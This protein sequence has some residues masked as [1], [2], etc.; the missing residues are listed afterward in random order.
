MDARLGTV[1]RF[2]GQQRHAIRFL[3]AIPAALADALV[4]QDPAG[5]LRQLPAT[6][7]AAFLR[8]AQLVVDHDRDTLHALEFRKYRFEI[9]ARAQLGGGRQLGRAGVF[10]RV[11]TEHYD[12]ADALGLEFARQGG[13]G[14]RS[15]GLLAA[16][17]GNGIVVE[18]LEC[19]VDARGHGR[20]H[21]QATGVKVRAVTEILEDVL[22]A[23]E[24]LG[25]DPRGAFGTHL[26]QV[27]DAAAHI[28]HQ[29]AHAV[30]ADAAS[31]DLALEQQRGAI[32][33]AAGAVARRPRAPRRRVLAR[34][35]SGRRSRRRRQLR[36]RRE[37]ATQR[38]RDHPRV[39]FAGRWQQHPA[40]CVPLAEDGRPL[41]AI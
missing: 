28:A 19:D 21:G 41:G 39:E 5:R 25:A 40:L 35:F 27:F 26:K 36:V 31:R 14:Q 12:L 6:A 3:D 18:N 33:G 22:R 4:D 34:H 11:V 13:H 20:L 7:P 23:A 15:G 32:V 9:L 16:G 38:K 1:F 2:D 17:H 37:V 24:G 30:T 29:A 8:R 10:G